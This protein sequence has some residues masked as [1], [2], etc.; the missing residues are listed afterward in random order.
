M[1]RKSLIICLSAIGAIAFILRTVYPFQAVFGLD[2]VN[3]LETDAWN[4]M[5][6]AKKL[7]AMPFL[8]SIN[9]TIQNNYLFSFMVGT[10]GRF[11]PIEIVGAWLP[12]F[13]AVAAVVV[14][15]FIGA[16]L[17]NPKVGLL[18]SLFVAIIPSE[19]LHRSLLGFADH[20]VLEVLLMALLV[21]FLIRSFQSK[22][23]FD[24]Y[25]IAAGV[26]LFF[27]MVNWKSGMYLTGGL[28]VVFGI[29]LLAWNVR[30][31]EKWYA[32]SLA[33]VL[34]LVLA[35]AIYLPLGG[36]RELLFLFPG[37]QAPEVTTTKEIADTLFEATKT[38]T[39]S[40]LMPLFA[41]YGKFDIRVV[42]T[43]LHLFALTFLG[44]FFFLWKYRKDK[45][46]LFFAIWTVVMLIITLNERRFLYYL[47]LPI[48]ILSAL[49][50][51]EVGSRLKGKAFQNAMI[52][53]VPLI[54]ISL[55][56]A[57]AMGTS[58]QYLMTNE[59]HKALVWLKDQPGEGAVSAW[60]D[61]GHWIQY[62]TGK[63]PSYMPGPG[64]NL[65]AKVFLSTDDAEA[66][67][68]LDEMNTDYLIVDEFTLARKY[69]ALV[70]YAGQGPLPQSR[71]LAFRLYYQNKIPSYLKLA[72]ESSTIRIFYYP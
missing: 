12:P 31:K 35:L 7:A 43:N 24:K 42:V 18:A 54:I 49:A 47:T 1:T 62:V 3:F 52:I 41:P 28:M 11:L 34:P 39:I 16:A 71:G 64:G 2:F 40:E 68:L 21:L 48:G 69:Q 63:P 17:F 44:G 29:A 13:I 38:R 30:H 72:Y 61:Y 10:L 51:V 67:R 57:K 33:V 25:S 59:W 5:M 32:H 70:I 46:V 27:Y 37:S 26:A 55:P 58:P 23:V 36:Y 45:S 19:F 22:A 50:V 65:I 20:H 56:L 53:A 60:S 15:Y 4:L 14:V 9:F 8:D 6:Y 66:K